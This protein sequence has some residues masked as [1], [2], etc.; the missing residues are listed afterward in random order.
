MRSDMRFLQVFVIASVAG[1]V[2]SDQ[3]IVQLKTNTSF[4]Q[5][6]NT[7]TAVKAQIASNVKKTI[8]IGP[9]EWLVMDIDGTQSA[10]MMKFD[11]LVRSVSPD[12]NLVLMDERA[13]PYQA[14]ATDTAAHIE[15]NGP[16]P[17][18]FDDFHNSH[19]KEESV[20]VEEA[21]NFQEEA[22]DSGIAD[23]KSFED[24]H[25][26]TDDSVLASEDKYA[27]ESVLNIQ[28]EA[29]YNSPIDESPDLGAQDVNSQTNAPS[30]LA[31]II[32]RDGIWEHS[33]P[34]EYQ[35]DTCGEGVV[36]YIIDS[37][38]N[39]DHPD[40]EGRATW[41]FSAVSSEPEKDLDGHG[42]HV[43]GLIGSKTYGVAKCTQLVSVK[44]MGASGTGSISD[45]L[46]GIEWAV[47]D[48]KQRGAK[49]VINMSI[50]GFYMALFND[51]ANAAADEGMV[52][53][54][55]AGNS[56]MSA[57]FTSPASA[58]KA[59]AVGAMDEMTDSI[60][61]FSNW[62]E[63]VAV[64][65]PGWQVE[66]LSNIDTENSIRH[67]G[68]SMASPIVAGVACLLLERGVP[69]DQM[70]S[71]IIEMSTQGALAKS[72]TKWKYFST[73]DR[74]VYIGPPTSDRKVARENPNRFIFKAIEVPGQ[75]NWDSEKGVGF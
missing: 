53:V 72:L 37:G 75:L 9:F 60:T 13:I 41:G 19:G 1:I 15:K 16:S 31:R 39:V 32:T 59:I 49:G 71:V 25:S 23:S 33:A 50:G 51:A 70:K 29:G 27:E 34:Y 4:A 24:H 56:D 69:T 46:E 26:T 28:V 35:Y 12:V 44:V 22:S 66:S 2:L 10:E 52:V 65:A 8:T 20:D 54:V 47:N 45:I 63:K 14:S 40:F 36:A 61:S 42:T 67:S 68:T 57:S 48:R 3:Y 62:G 74:V 38:V 30:H 5:F 21:A 43:C 58:E 64:F 18:E 7:H 17:L 6:L 11:P 55:A 73:Q